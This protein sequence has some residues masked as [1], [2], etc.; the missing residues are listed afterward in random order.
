M[1][2][3]DYAAYGDAAEKL[4]RAIKSSKIS[5]AYIFEGAYNID[6]KGFA[7][8]FAKA[9]LC[10]ND[11]GNGCGVC[12]VCGRIDS[13]N[14]EDV[15]WI[16]ADGDANKGNLSIR[17]EAIVELQ[18]NMM[19]KPTSGDR[20]I[21]VIQGCDGMTTRAQN[22][23]LKS[24]EEPSEGTVIMLLSENSR[25]LLPTINSRCIK[26]R[27]LDSG[28]GDA[29][30]ANEEKILHMRLLA[31]EFIRMLKSNEYFFNIKSRLE[32]SMFDKEC[33]C[34][35]LDEVECRFG[36]MLRAGDDVFNA[37]QVMRGVE[38]TEKAR[39]AIRR[40]IGYRYAVRELVLM[41]RTA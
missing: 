7:K 15:H 26:Y 31:D 6:K 12:P 1:S 20:N 18:R 37:S 5:H 30:G 41:L 35:F 25:N 38:L 23:F 36:D 24:L 2:L 11:R 14:H 33:A 27:L 4:A 3:S 9:I 21:V 16:S 34:I 22:R 19:L 17:D 40:N 28:M 8:E 39:N 29:A 32:E 13:E 10:P